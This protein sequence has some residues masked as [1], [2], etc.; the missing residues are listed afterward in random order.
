MRS[1]RPCGLPLAALALLAGVTMSDISR[2]AETSLAI[3]VQDFLQLPVDQ[4]RRVLRGDIVS[5]PVTENGEREVTVGLAMLVQAP[6]T[7]IAQYL[8]SGQLVAKDPSIGESGVL[9]SEL[10]P[11]SLV[12][13]GFSSGEWEEAQSLLEATPGTRFN[14][15]FAEI[16]A[17][18]AAR[19][20]AA[21]SSRPSMAEIASETYRRLLG[22]RAQSYRQGGLAGIAPYARGGGAVTDPASD[23][24][25]A[26]HDVERVGRAGSE[27]HEVL[28]RYPADQPPQLTSQVY[29]VKRRVQR[30]PHLSLLHRMVATGDGP[31]IHL[32][33][34][35]YVEHSFNSMQTLTLALAYED[36]TMVFSTTR[37]STDEVL[38]VGS[39][40]KRSVGR[41]QVR[42]E[43]R[44]RLERLRSAYAARPV[45]TTE[46]P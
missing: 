8:A 34:Y 30:R 18:R 36:A 1:L 2:A 13:P 26:V 6:V 5:Y 19:A 21:S 16:E 4:R 42:D 20:S 7:Q 44:A 9:P 40:L 15:S 35:F 37:V 3:E 32:E 17:L 14:L 41:G 24:R 10:S 12:G 29:W 23:L 11:G 43:M 45:V 46:S 38:G 27:F 39:H 22:L 33:R 25:A 28:Q 31:V